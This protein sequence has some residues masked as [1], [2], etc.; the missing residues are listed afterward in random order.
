MGKCTI[1]I[2]IFK[3]LMIII[4]IKFIIK[5]IKST[6][7][8]PSLSDNVP[9][10]ILPLALKSAIIA[11]IVDAVFVFRPLCIPIS[12]ACPII[13]SPLVHANKN[14]IHTI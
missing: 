5:I 3:K 10:I 9:S 13:R 4:V 11:T 1:Y 12:F 14:D 2:L 7:K 8:R 6:L